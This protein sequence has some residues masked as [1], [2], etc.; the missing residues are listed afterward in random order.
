MGL[1]KFTLPI[2]M[3]LS[4]VAWGSGEDGEP[5]PHLILAKEQEKSLCH[6]TQEFVHALKFLRATKEIVVTENSARL[7]AEKVSRGCDGAAER[8]AKVILLMKNVGLSDH[9]AVVLAIDFS[10]QSRDV[11]K[12]FLEIFTRVFLGEFFDYDYPTAYR[13]AID[14]SKNYKGEP[15]QVRD[16]FIELTR[17]CKDGKTLDL[18]GKL[19]ADYTVRLARLSQYH[20]SGI[21]K[22]FY[23]TFKALRDKKDFAF[24][25]KT[26]L[27]TTYNILKNG[28]RAADNFFTAY[29]Y[30]M[31]KDGLDLSKGEALGFALRMVDRSSVGT[32]GP[33]IIPAVNSTPMGVTNAAN[34]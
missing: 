30:G 14:L 24:D 28:P 13:L 33:P 31:Q 2:L 6:S 7:I 1:L 21:R 27:E 19:C 25:M 26:S 4:S 34:N 10:T 8:F 11:Q 3:A 12:N 9:K 22:A 18:P 32:E 29:R 16:D 15:S 5:D 23:D 20:P 17:F